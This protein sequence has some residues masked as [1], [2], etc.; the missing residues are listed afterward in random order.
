MP[1]AVN[2]HTVKKSHHV[3]HDNTNNLLTFSI[4]SSLSR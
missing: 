2:L 4:S 3:K 1:T